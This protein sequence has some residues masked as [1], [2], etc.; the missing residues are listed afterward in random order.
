VGLFALGALRLRHAPS[1]AF[2]QDTAQNHKFRTLKKNIESFG[3]ACGGEKQG[4]VCVA[5][6]S[7]RGFGDGMLELP[8]SRYLQSHGVHCHTQH[9]L[10]PTDSGHV[11]LSSWLVTGSPPVRASKWQARRRCSTRKRQ[12][13]DT[14][15]QCMTRF[16]YQPRGPKGPLLL[17]CAPARAVSLPLN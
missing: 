6:L 14:W 15:Q 7:S 1:Y 4:H 12:R 9:S 13:T 8:R 5:T 16:K 3:E 2:G 11:P 10:P 17:R